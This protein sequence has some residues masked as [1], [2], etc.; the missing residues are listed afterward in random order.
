VVWGQGASGGDEESYL[1]WD[2][3]WWMEDGQVS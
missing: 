3:G 2:K 1:Q